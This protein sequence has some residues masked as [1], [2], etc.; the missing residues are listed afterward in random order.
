MAAPKYTDRLKAQKLRSLAIDEMI[1][2][3]NGDDLDFK[4]QLLLRL[5]GGVLPRLNEHTGEEGGPINISFD[6]T[7]K[8]YA[9]STSSTTGDSKEQG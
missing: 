9:N 8:E 7:F 2:V 3:L 6:P 4:K 5:A 1:E